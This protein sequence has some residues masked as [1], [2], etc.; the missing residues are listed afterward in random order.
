MHV[1]S[2]LT[3]TRTTNDCCCAS[4][5]SKIL[6]GT[7][8]KLVAARNVVVE[9]NL[10]ASTNDEVAKPNEEKDVDEQEEVVCVTCKGECTCTHES[11]DENLVLFPS[12]P[13]TPHVRVIH[14]SDPSKLYLY[15]HESEDVLWSIDS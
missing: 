12:L 10:D 3:V 5:Y 1:Q 7:M 11:D 2:K 15:T 8:D 9:L 4:A 13:R 6:V 14:K